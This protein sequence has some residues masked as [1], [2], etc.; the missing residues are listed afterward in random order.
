MTAEFQVDEDGRYISGPVPFGYALWG[1]RLVEVPRELDACIT[2]IKMTRKGHA[3]AE[4]IAE[5]KRA[6]DVVPTQE[7]YDGLIRSVRR[8]YG[9]L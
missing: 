3:F 2:M 9:P 6:H 5:T 4:I 1:D 7:Q 8:R